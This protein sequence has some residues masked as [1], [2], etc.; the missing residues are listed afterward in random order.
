MT[1]PDPGAQARACGYARSPQWPAAEAAHLARCPQCACCLK[2][3]APVQVHHIFP[4]HLCIALG[5]PDL[6]LD[7]RNLITLCQSRADAPAPDHHLLVGHLESFQS[8]NLTV[9]QDAT[10]PFHGLSPA[11]LNLDPAWRARVQ[12]RLKPLD[13]L[14]PEA[15]AALRQAMDARFPVI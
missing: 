2:P 10:G 6:E 3:G 7:P 15:R 12:T 14:G 4:F 5:R 11:Q 8:A 9:P 1:T 13:Q